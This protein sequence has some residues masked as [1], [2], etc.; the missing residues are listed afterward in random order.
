MVVYR[1]VLKTVRLLGFG[2]ADKLDGSWS[3]LM[4]QLE[5]TVL[6]V[7]ARLAEI[8]NSRRVTYRL[9]FLV[10]SFAVALHV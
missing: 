5:E 4:Q 1:L 8:D 10:D 3:S 9:T 6:T 7:G 2:E